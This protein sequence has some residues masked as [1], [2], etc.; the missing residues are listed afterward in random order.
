MAINWYPGHMAIARKAAAESMR[1]I[2]LKASVVWPRTRLSA[3]PAS[4][5]QEADRQQP[6]GRSRRLGRSE[7]TAAALF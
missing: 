3:S 1:T 7:P 5:Q 4:Q 6:E 2:E